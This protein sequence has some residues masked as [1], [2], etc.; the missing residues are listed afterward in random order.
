[1]NNDETWDIHRRAI[2]LND[3]LCDCGKHTFWNGQRVFPT[4]EYRQP[5]TGEL[6]LE[7][8]EGPR[9]LRVLECQPPFVPKGERIIVRALVGK[10]ISVA[11]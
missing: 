8:P 7:L 5:E 10:T 11:P 6:F 9:V 4:G 3:T 1:M 2:A